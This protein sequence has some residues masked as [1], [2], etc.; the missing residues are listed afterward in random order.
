MRQRI[1]VSLWIAAGLAAGAV[2]NAGQADPVIRGPFAFEPLASSAAC[3]P[4]GAG[5][6][7]DEQPFPDLRANARPSDTAIPG[8]LTF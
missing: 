6:Y 1:L 3:V 5:T 2:I 4:G 7:P 8:R